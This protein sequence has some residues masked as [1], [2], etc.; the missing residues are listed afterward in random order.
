MAAATMVNHIFV[1]DEHVCC[2]FVRVLYGMREELFLIFHM[3]FW[4]ISFWICFQ[5][6]H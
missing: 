1:T 5:S 4:M 6:R 2:V 3:I